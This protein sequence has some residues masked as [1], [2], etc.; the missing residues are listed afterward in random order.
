MA[1]TSVLFEIFMRMFAKEIA[2][3]F[4]D[5]FKKRRMGIISHYFK[6]LYYSMYYHLIK[7]EKLERLF[8]RNVPERYRKEYLKIIK[9][10]FLSGSK[11]VVANIKH[12]DNLYF[13]PNWAFSSMLLFTDIRVDRY[14]K[15]NGENQWILKVTIPRGGIGIYNNKGRDFINNH[16]SINNFKGYSELQQKF[17]RFVNMFNSLPSQDRHSSVFKYG[18][19]K[20]PMRWVAGGVI[21]LITFRGKQWFAFVYRDI[22][23]VGFNHFGGL[24]ED[25][26]E[27]KRPRLMALREFLEEFLV[28][29]EEPEYGVATTLRQI[30]ISGEHH[31][32]IH[33]NRQF[34]RIQAYHKRLRELQDNIKVRDSPKEPVTMHALNTPFTV[35]EYDEDGKIITKVDD[36]IFSIDPFERGIEVDFIY[37]TNDIEDNNYLIFGEPD[38]TG[39]FLI[40]SPIVLISLDKIIDTIT[41]NRFLSCSSE[42]CKECKCISDLTEDDYIIFD[43]D[44]LDLRKERMI[45]LAKNMNIDLE[46]IDMLNS[47][48]KGNQ[49]ESELQRFWNKN[50]ADQSVKKKELVKRYELDTHVNIAI[51]TWSKLYTLKKGSV[52]NTE[53]A[54]DIVSRFCPVTWKVLTLA[55]NSKSLDPYIKK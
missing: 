7:W 24:S 51:N 29:D 36:T 27:R 21:P 22:P 5:T 44:T 35:E 40:R 39:S 3:S 20:N 42:N 1:I 52:I 41:S 49:V 33:L 43:K 13:W 15:S 6:P 19:E 9:E 2:Y 47:L 4:Y 37:Y 54:L 26:D 48:S 17:D 8:F 31:E 34:K 28:L 30:H 11:P 25:K 45:N 10:S 32:T 50:K 14:L 55:I 18:L 23:P 53:N 38:P 12:T 16:A 46:F